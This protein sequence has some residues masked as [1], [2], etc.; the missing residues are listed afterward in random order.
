M[1]AR[2]DMA[3]VPGKRG[4]RR[5][6][7][8]LVRAVMASE[9]V[10]GSVAI[11][12]LDETEMAGL[13]ERFRGSSGPTDVL[14]F[15]NDDGEGEWPDPA[16]RKT[17]DVGEVVVCP[18]VVERYAQEDDGDPETQMGWTILHG[19]LHLLGYDHEEDEGEMRARE[20]SLLVE[21][22]SKIRAA[23]AALRGQVS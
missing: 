22:D 8:D 19:V 11:A 14:S 3:P 13:N 17:K 6:V 20:R 12:F 21:L 7:R 18:A 4:A 10:G 15:S 23:S 1:R 9:D 2:V 16:G 5:A